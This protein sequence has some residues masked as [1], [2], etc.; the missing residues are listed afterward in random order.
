MNEIKKSR[1]EY[2]SQFIGDLAKAIFAVGFASYF[3]KEFPVWLRMGCG[4]LFFVFMI[5]SFYLHPG[6]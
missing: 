5:S 6:K 2:I 4:I 1:Q 3:F